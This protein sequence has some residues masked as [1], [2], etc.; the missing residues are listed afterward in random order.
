MLL[1]KLKLVNFRQFYSD[2]TVIEFS[3][4][5]DKN[6][7]LIHGENGIGKTTI[8]NA[9]LWCL[10]EKLTHDFEN[11]DESSQTPQPNQNNQAQ[12]ETN[13]DVSQNTQTEEGEQVET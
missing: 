12:P 4:D 1:Q 3:T 7:T 2:A 5:I 11:P 13:P 8:L 6:I 9:I 10:Y